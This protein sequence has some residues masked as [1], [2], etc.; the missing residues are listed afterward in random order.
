M[1]KKVNI[2]YKRFSEFL[3]YLKE[4]DA[5]ITIHH[6]TTNGNKLPITYSFHKDEPNIKSLI[7]DAIDEK[8]SIVNEYFRRN[9]VNHNIATRKRKIFFDKVN[10][11]HDIQTILPDAYNPSLQRK[12]LHRDKLDQT[13]LSALIPGFNKTFYGMVTKFFWNLLFGDPKNDY[14]TPISSFL[15]SKEIK[16]I[17]DQIQLLRDDE[18]FI[19]ACLELITSA[20]NNQTHYPDYS[21]LS[22]PAFNINQHL[23]YDEALYKEEIPLDKETCRKVFYGG[24][25]F[26]EIPVIE[27]PVNYLAHVIFA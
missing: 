3:N 9:I 19:T 14:F 21:F 5:E 6:Q 7:C 15:F 22:D 13:D 12:L 18:S 2:H 4:H 20:A 27:R 1:T 16:A 23:S 10:V 24:Y 17:R 8:E 26:R 25:L 11:I